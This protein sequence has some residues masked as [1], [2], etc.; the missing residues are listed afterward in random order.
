[1]PVAWTR[2][3]S[4]VLPL[5]WMWYVRNM[6][7]VPEDRHHPPGALTVSRRYSFQALEKG[8]TPSKWMYELEFR[9]EVQTERGILHD[10]QGLIPGGIF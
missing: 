1:M 10:I 8:Q 4:H 2:G 5:Q 9:S 7:C 6:V 3:S